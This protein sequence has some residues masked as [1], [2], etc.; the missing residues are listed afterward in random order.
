MYQ[1][2]FPLPPSETLPTMYDLPSEDPEELGLP[3]EF[4]DFQPKL[5]RE[6]CQPKIYLASEHF[7]GADLNLYYDGR[8]PR[9]Y[10][11]PD[12][13]LVLGVSMADRQEDLRWSYV[14]WQEFVSP[15]LVVEL[16]SPGTESEDLGSKIRELGKPPTKWEV[17][18][19]ILRVPFYVVF[20]RYDNQ[21]RVFGLANGRYQAIDV[22]GPEPR[23]WFDELELG[24]GVWQGAY[25]GIE[26]KWM[27]WYEASGDWIPTE[28]EARQLAETQAETERSARELAETQAETERSARQRAETQAE[29]ERSARRS[30]IPRLASFGLTVEQIAESL[31]LS[32]AEVQA[33]IDS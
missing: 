1:S 4:H 22:S 3:D 21:L 5:L 18:E 16:L 11:R 33:E 24:L 31:G 32:I 26:G 25:Q 28:V 19:R 27:R 9:W 17:Y 14:M 30:A 10:K 29:T 2:Q 7:L 20:D 13:F 12:W 23:V 6:T 8:H 15:F